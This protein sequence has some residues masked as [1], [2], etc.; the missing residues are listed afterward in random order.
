MTK[1]ESNNDS[2]SLNGKIIFFILLAI[3]LI[4]SIFFITKSYQQLE[5]TRGEITEEIQLQS[6]SIKFVSETAS[7]DR[8]LLSELI[9]RVAL[10]HDVIKLRHKRAVAFI[11]TRTWMR[12]MTLV[13]GVI[14]VVVGGSFILGRIT[15][16]NF[17]GKAGAG[18]LSLSFAS[19]SPGII[20]VSFGTI[21][22][23]I[24]NLASQSIETVDKPTYFN[25]SSDMSLDYDYGKTK[26]ELLNKILNNQQ[27]SK[28]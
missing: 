20:L 18:E 27:G 25:S 9:A 28:L 23:S 19:S 17:V 7:S 24:P 10:E 6:K 21:L 16:P 26:Q 11:E 14:L 4:P 12:F 5:R 8:I 13:I 15:A 2:G 3:L 1:M 22:I